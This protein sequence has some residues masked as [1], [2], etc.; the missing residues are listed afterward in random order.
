MKIIKE[1]LSYT[2]CI[3][4]AVILAILVNKLILFKIKVPTA[5]MYPTIK[6]N[7]QIFV[8]RIYNKDNLKTGDIVV[9]K[10]KELKEELVKRLIGIPNDT[11]E[12]TDKGIVYVNG[13]QLDEPY[14]IN[15]GGKSGIY[16]VPEGHYF[17]LGDN[18]MNSRDSRYWNNPYIDSSDIEGK[19]Q[20]IVYPFNRFG[21]LK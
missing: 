8:T 19:A 2:L 1:I 7:D 13:K 11:V 18:R 5:S 17:F 4:A 6:I 3:M 20:I 12:I 9:F 16:K 21:F 10:S 14:V 15:N